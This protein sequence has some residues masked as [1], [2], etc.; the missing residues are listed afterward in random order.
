MTTLFV[1]HWPTIFLFDFLRYAIPASGLVALLA[2]LSKR[3]AHRRIQNRNRTAQDVSRELRYSLSTIFIFSLTGFAIVVG[4]TAGWFDIKSGS[5]S[6]PWAMANLVF[7]IVLHDAYFYWTHRAMHHKKLFK[8]FHRTHHLSR[9]PAPWAAY[10]FAPLEALVE[11]LFLP[12]YLLF[13]P[14]HALVI[15]IFLVHMIVRNVMGHAG[16]ELF[17]K[18]W[19]SWPV[20][21]HITVTSHHDMHHEHF[22]C[23]YALYFTWWDRWMGT[24]HVDYRKQ[25]ESLSAGKEDQ[26]AK[27]E[28]ARSN[29]L[30]VLLALG[31]VFLGGLPEQ[32]KAAACELDGDWV[33][34]G[35]EAIVSVDTQVASTDIQGT[36]RWVYDDAY[37]TLVGENIFSG[38]EAQACAW[39]GGLILD[40]ESGRKYRSTIT[41]G[42]DDTLQIKACY[43]PF[44]RKQRWQRYA[45]V[46]DR[47]PTLSRVP[48]DDELVAKSE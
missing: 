26:R 32:A 29:L 23:N 36:I 38:F 43:G 22:N 21:R 35:F 30:I 41:L 42:D 27:L 12:L 34:N 8:W 5:I 39:T 19:M 47:L 37:K 17:P 44:C 25:F 4:E 7:I 1:A 10:S 9:T 40:P 45:T 28:T 18:H 11:A 46:L 6:I 2:C 24:E 48:G 3:L 14:T 31:V 16:I 15:A 33:T 20:L 13:V